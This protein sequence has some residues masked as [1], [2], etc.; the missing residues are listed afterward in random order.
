MVRFN[1]NDHTDGLKGLKEEE[2]GKEK[3]IEFI[4]QKLQKLERGLELELFKR[5][6]EQKQNVRTVKRWMDMMKS[7]RSKNRRSTDPFKT[8]S[9]NYLR[10]KSF[11]MRVIK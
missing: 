11:V 6:C 3:T 2:I 8:S 10:K 4:S 7:V 1:L 5:C 9:S